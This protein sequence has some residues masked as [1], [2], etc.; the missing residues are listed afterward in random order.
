MSGQHEGLSAKVQ[1]GTHTVQQ[2]ALVE[3]PCFPVRNYE[4]DCLEVRN[5]PTG[6]SLQDSPT[7]LFYVK[8]PLEVSRGLSEELGVYYA[9]CFNEHDFEYS[10]L[11]WFIN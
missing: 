1:V 11:L 4:T 5:H 2:T 9:T 3:G 10:D 8:T 7:G 6:Q